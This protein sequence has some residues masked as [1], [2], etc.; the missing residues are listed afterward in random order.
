VS[1]KIGIPSKNEKLETVKMKVNSIG[2]ENES[3]NED[4]WAL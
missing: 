4:C 1:K 2:S 3:E